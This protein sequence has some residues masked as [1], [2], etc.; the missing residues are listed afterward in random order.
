MHNDV[1]IEDERLGTGISTGN[2]A[3][4]RQKFEYSGHVKARSAGTRMMDSSFFEDRP[5]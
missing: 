4:E 2:S 3:L 1:N 5:S